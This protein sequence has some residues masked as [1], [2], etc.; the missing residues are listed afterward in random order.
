V[1][2]AKTHTFNLGGVPDSAVVK[3]RAFCGDT[4]KQKAVV[5]RLLL[6]FVEQPPVVQKVVMGEVTDGLEDDY[7]RALESL[8]TAARKS[9]KR[10]G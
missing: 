2:V 7:A 10:A 8:A 3:L 1:S 4:R 9:K 5:T 6:W